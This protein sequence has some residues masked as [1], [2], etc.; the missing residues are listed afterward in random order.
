[1]LGRRREVVGE[2]E[3]GDHFDRIG[4]CMIYA[5]STVLL[6]VYIFLDWNNITSTG[7]QRIY[8][9]DHIAIKIVQS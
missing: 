5:R 6:W 7:E 2:A 4:F 1:M 9:M 3:G 8:N